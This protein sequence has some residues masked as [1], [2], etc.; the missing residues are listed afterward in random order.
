MLFVDGVDSRLD[1]DHE[2]VSALWQPNNVINE[3]TSD[4][5][6]KVSEWNMYGAYRLDNQSEEVIFINDK[7]EIEATDLN[8]NVAGHVAYQCIDG[9]MYL[10]IR[11]DANFADDI[12]I[13]SE[14]EVEDD[15]EPESTK[16]GNCRTTILFIHFFW[17][18]TNDQVQSNAFESIWRAV[19]RRTSVCAASRQRRGHGRERD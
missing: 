4:G 14:S 1:S 5:P 6:A 8:A 9:K 12:E 18:A 17:R 10:I 19:L 13:E 3:T 2:H 7:G 11:T 15:P 16:R